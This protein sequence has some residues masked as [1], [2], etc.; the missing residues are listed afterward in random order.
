M[1]ASTQNGQILNA[2]MARQGNMYTMIPARVINYNSKTQ[3]CEAEVSVRRP[4][5]TEDSGEIV[6]VREVP[7]GFYY[8]SDWV[9]AAP[10]KKGDAV[11]LICPMMNIENWLTGDRDKIYEA[12]GYQFHNLDGAF[13]LPVA[14][15]YS[16]PTRDER[17]HDI[18][19]IVQGDNYI[20]MDDGGLNI[21][22][23]STSINLSK[24]GNVDVTAP[25]VNIHGNATVSGNMSVTGT[26][27]S[28]AITAP[29][30]NI[31]GKQ[32][33]NHN[34]NYTDDGVGKVTGGNN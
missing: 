20:T 14:F 5:A 33:A 12:G 11:L 28:G 4:Y 30:A 13:A 29:S 6:R 26:L 23:G 19:H 22:S 7:V 8:G 17:F 10:L 34:H 31:A 15:T 24:S 25:T 2:M 1:Q 9:I 16:K 32:L 21:V 18:F 27:T 3:T